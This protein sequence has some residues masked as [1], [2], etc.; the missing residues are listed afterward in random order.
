MKTGWRSKNGMGLKSR[1]RTLAEPTSAFFP[2]LVRYPGDS[3]ASIGGR[4]EWM[5]N[6]MELSL[7]D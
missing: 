4:D 2:T 1:I 5:E 6:Q 7:E 3:F